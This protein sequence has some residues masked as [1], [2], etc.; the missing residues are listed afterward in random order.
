VDVR[1]AGLMAGIELATVLPASRVAAE[2]YARG[3]FTRPIGQTIQLVPPL[4]SSAAELT[5]F[6][7]ALVDVLERAA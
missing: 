4:C 1:R 6:V 2:L 3:Q 5:A 7:A